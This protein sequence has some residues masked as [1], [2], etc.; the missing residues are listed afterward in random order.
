MSV[1]RDYIH[2][3]V[4]GVGINVGKQDFPEEIAA[5][6]ASLEE[7]CGHPV[8]RAALVAAVMKAFEKYYDRFCETEDMS[9]LLSEYNTQ[10]V[11]MNR[12]VKVLDPKGEYIGISRG[13]NNLGELLVE[14]EDGSV[15]AVYAGEVSVRGIYGYT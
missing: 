1:E 2:Y 10:L 12:E 13:I 11:N 15:N 7:C 5:V 14:R 3:I 6:A 9:G 8:S 4:I